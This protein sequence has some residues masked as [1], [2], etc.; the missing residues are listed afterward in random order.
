MA[1]WVQNNLLFQCDSQIDLFY[2]IF[3]NTYNLSDNMNADDGN[4]NCIKI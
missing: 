2:D 3:S 4:S 1:F